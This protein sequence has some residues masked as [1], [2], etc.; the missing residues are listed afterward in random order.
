MSK[1]KLHQIQSHNKD[2][3]HQSKPVHGGR[4]AWS[5]KPMTQ[6]VSNQ[7]AKQSR[8]WCRK[9]NNDGFFLLRYSYFLSFYE[10][11]QLT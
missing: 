3:Q 7:K 9:G 6:I 8:T 1:T 10:V 5:R 2:I 4:I 11:K